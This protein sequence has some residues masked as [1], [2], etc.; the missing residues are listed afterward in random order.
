MNQYQYDSAFFNFVDTSSTRSA[1][2]FLTRFTGGFRPDSLLDIGC[3]RGA[4]LRAWH[5]LGLNDF[6]GVDGNYVEQDS[7]LIPPTCFQARDISKPFDLKRKFALV[8]CLEVAEHIPM[9]KADTLVNNIVTHGDIILF[10]AAQPGQGGEFHVN[11]QPLAFWMR[12]FAACGY[13]TFDFPRQTIRGITSIEPW[14]RYN[15]IL[16]ANAIGQK[17][18]TKIVLSTKIDK[19]TSSSYFSTLW[20]LRCGVL[21]HIPQSAVNTA[22]RVKH[23]VFNLVRR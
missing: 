19:D 7:L 17:N 21:V 12:K 10:S 9:G 5:E 20:K 2:A 8:E 18:L 1:Q 16:L 6:C 13:D 4:W 15:T 22:A 3:G 11:E 14:Y 23:Q